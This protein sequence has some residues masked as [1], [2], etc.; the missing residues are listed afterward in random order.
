MEANPIPDINLKQTCCVNTVENS[1]INNEFKGD[2]L[3]P[4]EHNNCDCEN[5]LEF[6]CFTD[7][8]KELI[9]SPDNQKKILKFTFLYYENATSDF[10]VKESFSLLYSP[11]ANSTHF[12]I[13][14]V[15]L[16]I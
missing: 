6:I 4:Y 8:H 14:S 12:S 11:Q 1:S 10:I 2:V 13:R 5:G 7:K 15:V 16:L 3:I 9:I